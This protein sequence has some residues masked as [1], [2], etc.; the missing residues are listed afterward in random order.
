[1]YE[2]FGFDCLESASKDFDNG[3]YVSAF[4]LMGLE[5]LTV[6]WMVGQ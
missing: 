6:M 4:V 2:H 5:L 3:I 1:M